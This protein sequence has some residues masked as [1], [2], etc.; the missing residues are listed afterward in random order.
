MANCFRS[1]RNLYGS[2]LMI[3]MITILSVQLN[4]MNLSSV[5]D[6]K[7]QCSGDGLVSHC[8]YLKA[9]ILLFNTM[10]VFCHFIK[11]I[12]RAHVR[13]FQH[14][15]SFSS[16]KFVRICVFI[17]KTCT[18]NVYPLEPHFYIVKLVY[19]GVY[20]FLMKCFDF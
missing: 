15:L 13:C 14:L 7:T 19:A 2:F 11:R 10:V 3:K 12:N 6:M 5:S 9:F 1:V 4:N 16:L 8:L 20:L 18:C 17:R